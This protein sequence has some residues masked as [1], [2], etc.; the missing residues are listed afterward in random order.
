MDDRSHLGE[1]PVPSFADT[2]AEFWGH[3]GRLM[4]AIARPKSVRMPTP[5]KP[6]LNPATPEEAMQ[7]LVQMFS[8]P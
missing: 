5:P 8:R 7:L 1:H 3:L 6:P 2:I 4:A